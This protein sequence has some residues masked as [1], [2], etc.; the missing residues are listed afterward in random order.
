MLLPNYLSNRKVPINN[1]SNTYLLYIIVEVL[2]WRTPAT[3]TS[4]LTSPL[5]MEWE[6]SMTRPSGEDSS[7]RCG[8]LSIYLPIYDI[9]YIFIY[10]SLPFF[11]S[12]Y[13]SLSISVYPYIYLPPS[14]PL[15]YSFFIFFPPHLSILTSTYIP[16]SICGVLQVYGILMCQLL[17]TGA[18][19]AAFLYV[20]DLQRL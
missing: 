2:C 17:V 7:E 4:G 11:F 12:L 19:I 10:L 16:L 9:Q 1:G 13:P 3:T 6:A 20:R 14:H 5:P 18:I 15:K 8:F